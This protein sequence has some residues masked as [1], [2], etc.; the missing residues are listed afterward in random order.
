MNLNN[1]RGIVLR[2]RPNGAPKESD[3]EILSSQIQE[4]ENNE[5]LVKGLYLSL[6]PY[7]RGRMSSAK[8]YAPPIAIGELM[9]GE[10]VG[11]V[12]E[13]KHPN[14][15]VGDYVA[16]MMGWQ[17]YATVSGDNLR[18][19]PSD[20]R[21]IS[22]ALGIL[23]MPGLTAYFG[24]FEV[25]QPKPGETVLVSAAS[26]A[27]GSVVGQ[28]AKSAGC[29]V[30]GIV[31]SELKAKYITSELNYDEAINYRS[32]KDIQQ[33]VRDICPNGVNIY[34]DNVGGSIT[35]SV[36]NC[37]ALRAK[38]IVC[39]MIAQYNLQKSYLGPSHLRSIL[40]SRARVEGFLIFDWAHRYS[41][42]LSC[43]KKMISNNEL[44]Y[45]E[46][47]VEGI[48]NAPAAFLGLFDGK[49]LGKRL[50]RLSEDT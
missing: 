46:D 13:S 47:I 27:V 30:I 20:I 16:G 24:L 2:S 50:V 31:G 36:M 29:R 4:P 48:E 42:G 10:S 41:E 21:P 49:N 8:S 39:G 38:V 15:N 23:G 5:V 40:I 43:L 33:S 11:K 35:D 44:F 1:S 6:D 12:V 17:E 45:N 25:G 26:G 32:C 34:F 14:Y 3:F 18:K 9:V 37:L 7:M 22:Y 28:L 19:I